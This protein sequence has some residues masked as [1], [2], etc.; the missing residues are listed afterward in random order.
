LNTDVH[1]ADVP[2]TRC[3]RPAT[4]QIAHDR[5]HRLPA[6]LAIGRMH[7]DR[8]AHDIGRMQ[9]RPPDRPRHDRADTDIILTPA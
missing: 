7:A 6:P 4:P 2:V 1:G 5:T 3:S 9:A 8:A